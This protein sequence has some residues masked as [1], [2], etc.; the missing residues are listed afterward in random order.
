M[1]KLEALEVNQAGRFY[2]FFKNVEHS[3]MCEREKGTAY[4]VCS[5]QLP[6]FSNQLALHLSASVFR[7]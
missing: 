2:Q 3:M 5:M 6:D 1:L 7:L 4:T